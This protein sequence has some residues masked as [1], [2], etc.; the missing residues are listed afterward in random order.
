[1]D[2]RRDSLASLHSPVTCGSYGVASLDAARWRRRVRRQSEDRVVTE[3]SMSEL[4]GGQVEE[5]AAGDWS[6]FAVIDGHGGSAAA[7]LVKA[8]LPELVAM[9]DGCADADL[10]AAL[11]DALHAVET[12]L[13]REKSGSDDS[14]ACVVAAAIART[15][16][17]VAWV[18]DCRAVLCCRA[19]PHARQLTDDHSGSSKS[20]RDRITAAGGSFDADGY[21]LGPDLQPTRT[22]G[23]SVAKS[24]SPGLI[25][26]EPEI[27]YFSAEELRGAT[28]LLLASDGVW[29]SLSCED[30]AHIVTQH[31]AHSAPPTDSPRKTS[32]TQARAWVLEGGSGWAYHAA[33]AVVREAALQGSGDDTTA[34]VIPLSFSDCR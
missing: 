15:G 19:R 2:S 7:E 1:M 33:K 11:C 24:S 5:C 13:V 29:D 30:A 25:L 16:M 3:L 20:E 31:S 34:L 32:P 4:F 21:V 12:G 23:D 18:G 27:K 8:Q 22:L 10:S 6:L 17:H 28:A 14:G 26:S 9:S